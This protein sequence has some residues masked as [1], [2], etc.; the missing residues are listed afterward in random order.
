MIEKLLDKKPI[1]PI[2]V[3]KHDLEIV[4]YPLPEDFS[5]RVVLYFQ[6]GNF[7]NLW[8]Q[9]FFNK[10]SLISPKFPLP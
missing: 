1:K 7:Q 6:K 4:E 10:K 5:G 8:K 9:Q 3:I 2:I